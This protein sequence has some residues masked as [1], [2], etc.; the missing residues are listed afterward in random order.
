MSKFT[1]LYPTRIATQ[2]YEAGDEVELPNSTDQFFIKRLIEIGCLKPIED[3]TKKAKKEELRGTNIKE[4]KS[5]KPKNPTTQKQDDN[6]LDID[7]SE[8]EE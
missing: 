6:D 8:I 4:L 5:K 7:T 3:D 1:V 2:H